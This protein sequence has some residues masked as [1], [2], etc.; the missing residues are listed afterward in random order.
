MV[1]TITLSEQKS[2]FDVGLNFKDNSNEERFVDEIRLR[3]DKLFW[4]SLPRHGFMYDENEN[5][6]FTNISLSLKCDRRL[7]K[8]GKIEYVLFRGFSYETID[9]L[10]EDEIPFNKIEE[11][12]ASFE[13]EKESFD[14]ERR[15][16]QDVMFD[17]HRYCWRFSKNDDGTIE[18]IE[19]WVPDTICNT[20]Q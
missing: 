7:K 5:L 8:N 12:E 18:F 14:A 6:K 15:L 13:N 4:K 3:L 20:S 9:D 17:G 1:E 10:F 11:L 16:P 19:K 2:L